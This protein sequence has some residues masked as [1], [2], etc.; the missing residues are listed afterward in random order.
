MWST[1]AT[2]PAERAGTAANRLHRLLSEL[3]PGQSKRGITTSQAEQSATMRPRDVAGKTR[4]RL[5]A[6][7]WPSWSRWRR[8]SRR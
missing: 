4:R 2:S 1:V 6:E 3:V 7:Q 5:A 8:R